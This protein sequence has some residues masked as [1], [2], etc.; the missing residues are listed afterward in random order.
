MVCQ[1]CSSVVGLN[2]SNCY[3]S[4]YCIS[5]DTGYVLFTANHSCIDY[6]PI[7]YANISGIAVPCSSNCSRCNVT[8]TNCTSCTTNLSLYLWQNN[9]YCVSIC[10]DGTLSISNICTDCTYPCLN[11]IGEITNC[12][13][14]ITGYLM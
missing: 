7:G 14:C 9:G 5:C 11:C 3:N 13:S 1:A 4:T 2:C 10:P 12:S 8:T 6:V